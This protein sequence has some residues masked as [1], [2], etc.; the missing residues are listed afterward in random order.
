MKWMMGL[1]VSSVLI[2][3]SWA[4]IISVS[5]DNPGG[6]TPAIGASD[7]AGV[8]KAQ[9]WNNVGSSLGVNYYDNAG[10]LTTLTVGSTKTGLDSWNTAGT[11][12]Q[13]IYGD[14]INAGNGYTLSL[15]SIPYA[16]Y[17]LVVYHSHYAMNDPVHVN[18]TV[19][20]VTKSLGEDQVAPWENLGHVEGVTYVR[21]SGLKDANVSVVVSTTVGETGLAGFQISQVPEPATIGLLGMAAIGI[22]ARRRAMKA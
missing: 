1:L 3:Q 16:E 4:G 9:N 22:L 7:F 10:Q 18:F 21:F 12:D 15:G 13:I 5:V 8:F 19:G 14:W 2:S 17:D 11:P 20:S 6:S